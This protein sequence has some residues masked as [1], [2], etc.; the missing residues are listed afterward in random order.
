MN[1]PNPSKS[2]ICS[3]QNKITVSVL[4]LG[5]SEKKTDVFRSPRHPRL[6]FG[7]PLASAFALASALA[8]ALGAAFAGPLELLAA[9]ARRMVDGVGWGGCRVGRFPG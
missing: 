3:L 2:H 5:I 1:H 4:R 7:D 9:S 6:F 8:F